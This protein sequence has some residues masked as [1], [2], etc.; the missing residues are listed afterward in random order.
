MGGFGFGPG[1]PFDSHDSNESEGSDE[2][3]NSNNPN[4]SHHSNDFNN[5][6]GPEHE[7]FKAFSDFSGGLFS[8]MDPNA[9][10]IS[11]ATL[12]QSALQSMKEQTVHPLGLRDNEEMREALDIANLWLDE[13]MTFPT[14]SLAAQPAWDRR[15]WLD[16]T[17]QGWQEFVEPLA[18]GMA[19]ALSGVIGEM[20]V[21]TFLP[22][23]RGFMGSLIAN[24]LGQA[25]AH[26]SSKV[27][28][29]NDGAIP[30]FT[31]SESHLLPQNVRAWGEGL[32]IPARDIRIFLAVREAA[33][34]R[35]FSHAEWLRDY[36]RDAITAYG[37]GI[38]IDAAAIQS[39][40]ESA[41]SS[42]ELDIENPESINNAIA[43][44]MFVPE[45][46]EAQIAALE[47][48]EMAL[49]LIEGWLEH[50]SSLACADRLPTI[51][52]LMETQRRA[53]AT[54]SPTQQLFAAMLGL[55]ISPRKMRECTK[56]WSDVHALQ[57]IEGRDHR[58]EDASLLPRSED[59]ADAAGFLQS[60]TVPDDLSGLI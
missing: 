15:Q 31:K 22:V 32:D 26:L 4:G 48:V 28:G 18:E 53:R 52:N 14:T 8:P 12:R 34:T 16:A 43:Q 38:K 59:L 36:L 60:T 20:G 39:Q 37:K 56:F 25:V 45:Q 6:N 3:N 58:W 54:Q 1:D 50:I 46:S 11:S 42:G 40:A 27:T 23:M 30:L 5:S 44:G 21:E 57:G 13:V 55:E 17:L 7:L 29:A 41:I 51:N 47:R 19:D 10:M 9:A 33:A 35:L 49:A 2:L 24:Q